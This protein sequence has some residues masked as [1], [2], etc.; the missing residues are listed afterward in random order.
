MI[1]SE[2]TKKNEGGDGTRLTG[3]SRNK[4][5]KAI[6]KQFIWSQLSDY[7]KVYI[8]DPDHEHQYA[9]NVASQNLPES[10][11]TKI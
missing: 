8:L 9:F 6:I 11:S 2:R 5:R 1:F 7:H 3:Y 10:K 4:L